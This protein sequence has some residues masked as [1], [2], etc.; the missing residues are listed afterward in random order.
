MRFSNTK[1]TLFS[2]LLLLLSALLSAQSKVELSKTIQ[3]NILQQNERYSTYLPN[4]YSDTTNYPTLYL[5]HGY[6]GNENSWLKQGKLHGIIDSL[7]NVKQIPPIIVICPN[8]RN[9]YFINDYKGVY[10]FEDYFIQELIPYI[11]TNYNTSKNKPETAIAGLSMGGFGATVLA[12][13][14]PTT[15]GTSVNLS[16]AVR[17]QQ[18]FIDLSPAKYFRYFAPIYGDSLL[19]KERITQHWKN[20]SPYTLIDSSNSSSY[21]ETNWYIDCGMYDF[22]FYSNQSL[23]H[24][25]LKNNIPHEY[26]MRIGKHEWQYWESGIIKALIYWGDLLKKQSTFNQN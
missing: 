2:G 9:S 5:F 8:A 11:N 19:G 18:D 20:N 23:H 4:G 25:F 3:S 22:L 10:R 24:L 6:G 16:G 13:K 17:T 7:I 26:H 15:F 1:K 14:H 21:S 12:I